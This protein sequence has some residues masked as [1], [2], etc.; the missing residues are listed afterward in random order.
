MAEGVESTPSDALPLSR[1]FSPLPPV[2][3]CNFELPSFFR[4][5]SISLFPKTYPFFFLFL[6]LIEGKD[7]WIS[8]IS[9]SF[10]SFLPSIKRLHCLS[11][12][13]A[14]SV[15]SVLSPSH[16]Y[17]IAILVGSPSPLLASAYTRSSPLLVPT[18]ARHSARKRIGKYSRRLL[19]RAYFWPRVECRSLM[20]H[21]M[22]AQCIMHARNGPTLGIANVIIKQKLERYSP[23]IYM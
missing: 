7:T 4:R 20:M 9:P 1:S 19:T 3:P 12:H 14:L 5:L 15:S 23:Y 6:R 13:I 10:L 8:E 2:S 21:P 18:L 22:Q 16:L 11:P 17:I